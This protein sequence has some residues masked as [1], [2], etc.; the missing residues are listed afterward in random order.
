MG[1][2]IPKPTAEY[3]EEEYDKIMGVNLKATYRSCQLA[4]PMLKA[5]KGASITMIS[6]VAGGP[7]SIKSGSLYAMS[8]GMV[9]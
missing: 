7:A 8:K 2:N 1:C 6:S 5:A 3:T 9:C 4:Y